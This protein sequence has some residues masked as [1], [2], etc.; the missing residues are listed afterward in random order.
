MSH[1]PSQCPGPRPRDR[2]RAALSLDGCPQ[3]TYLR[4]ARLTEHTQPDGIWNVPRRAVSWRYSSWSRDCVSAVACVPVGAPGVPYTLAS[5]DDPYTERLTCT[6]KHTL[7]TPSLKLRI[8]SHTHIRCVG[9]YGER[10]QQRQSTPSRRQATAVN[11]TSA[12]WTVH[13]T[14]RVHRSSQRSNTTALAVAVD[15][16]HPPTLHTSSSTAQ[17]FTPHTA[18]APLLLHPTLRLWSIQPTST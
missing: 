12:A 8:D 14:V 4:R 6:A 15:H 10:D 1:W 11:R 18:A 2:C 9:R 3:Q 5:G 7:T 16:R 17:R 13:H